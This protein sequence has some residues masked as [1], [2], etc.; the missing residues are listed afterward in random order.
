MLQYERT[1]A[2]VSLTLIGLA[3]YFALEV[4]A[5]LTRV[6]LLGTDLAITASRRWLMA[7]LLVAVV[8]AGADMVV[9][10]QPA[11][12]ER[13]LAYLATFWVLPGLLVIVLIQALGFA[14]NP[15][16]WGIS[17]IGAGILLWLTIVAAFH[18]AGPKGGAPFW[19]YLWEQLMADAL[20][21]IL[22]TLLYQA[23]Q[24]AL[25]SA[26]A[27][28][29]VSGMLA[30]P[31]LRQKSPLITK[32]WLFASV[33]GLALGQ[34]TWAIRFWP[35]TALQAGLILFLLFYLLVGLTQQFLLARLSG[36]LVGEYGLIAAL[37]LVVIYF[38]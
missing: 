7:L 30:L 14:P 36:R 23:G 4:P 9:R 33:I 3:L 35:V 29:M 1:N 31:L 19:A 15:L 37:A 22:F 32:S 34:A 13:R 12:L 10:A 2:V 17:L 20:A 8:M 16:I 38:L 18:Q 25:V 28:V 6:P 21:L 27:M 11:L 5:R 24:R 26:G